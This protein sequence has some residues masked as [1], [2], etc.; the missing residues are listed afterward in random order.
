MKSVDAG[1]VAEELVV[2]FSRVGVPRK[3]L[4]DQGSNFT[5]QLLKEVSESPYYP[6]TNG[7]VE[8]FNQMLKEML[9]KAATDEGKD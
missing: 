2:L 5:S 4:T 7:P 6:Q 9:R 3:I 8:K 1:H